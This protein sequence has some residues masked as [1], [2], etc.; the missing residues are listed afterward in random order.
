MTPTDRVRVM[1]APNRA[2]ACVRARLRAADVGAQFTRYLNQVYAVKQAGHVQ[3]DG[4]N[5]F[6]YRDVAG[7]PGTVDV[8]FG[9]GLTQPFAGAGDVVPSLLPS[10][11]A[12][13]ATHTGSYAGLG[14]THRAIVEWCRANGRALAGPRWEVYGH[15]TDDASQLQTKIWYLLAP[16]QA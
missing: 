5:I 9:V 11:D 14:D 15:W 3:L 4:Q 2:F 7:M 16:A 8:E 6:V 12:A 13:T 10:G 1:P